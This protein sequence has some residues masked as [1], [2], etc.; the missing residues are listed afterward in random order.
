MVGFAHNRT[1]PTLL[2][3]AIVFGQD[4]DA[5]DEGIARSSGATGEEERKP[6]VAIIP[7]APVAQERDDH[8]SHHAEFRDWCPWCVQVKNILR[9]H[10]QDTKEMGSY[11]ESRLG[12]C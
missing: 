2:S 7:R 4:A 12:F 11:G 5:E 1:S 9:H 3:G 10:V 6:K 8:M